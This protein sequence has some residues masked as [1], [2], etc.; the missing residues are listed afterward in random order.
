MTVT[1]EPMI[2]LAGDVRPGA[3]PSPRRGGGRPVAGRPRPGAGGARGGARRGGPPPLPPTPREALSLL[4][5]AAD[6]LAEGHR[7][8]DP[9]HRYP[10]AYLAALRAGAA[11]LAMRARP[12]PRR[13]APRDVWQLLAEVAPELEEWA[14]FFASCSRTRAAAEAG[15]SRAVTRRDADDL[16]RQSEQ[17][18]ELV[19]GLLP[20]R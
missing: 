13:G 7:E 15:I 18:V 6:Q 12:R 17:F 16:L 1:T 19:G 20:V 4:R 11:V 14:V 3:V 8:E 9:L 2:D 10:A 5:Q